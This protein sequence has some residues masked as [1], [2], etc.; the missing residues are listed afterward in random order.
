MVDATCTGLSYGSSFTDANTRF[1][2]HNV[3]PYGRHD[4]VC[5]A[6]FTGAAVFRYALTWF[7]RAQCAAVLATVYGR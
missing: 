4:N 6:R 5:V 1:S 2:L 7:P 3:I